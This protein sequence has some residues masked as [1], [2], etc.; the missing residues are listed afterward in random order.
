MRPQKKLLCH[1]FVILITIL[2]KEGCGNSRSFSMEVGKPLGKISDYRVLGFRCFTCVS[3]NKKLRKS[4][5]KRN[6]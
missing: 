5:N 3:M 2:S 1:I 6:N 4:G